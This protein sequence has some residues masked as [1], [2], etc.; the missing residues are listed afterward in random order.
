[1]GFGLEVGRLK[2]SFDDVEAAREESQLGVGLVARGRDNS[3]RVRY[4]GTERSRQSTS[5]QNPANLALIHLAV[6][7]RLARR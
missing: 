6:L 4:N 3:S 1:M 2:P 5:E 7:E